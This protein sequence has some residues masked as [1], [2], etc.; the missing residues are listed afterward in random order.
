MMFRL[1]N[2]AR[3]AELCRECGVPVPEEDGIVSSRAELDG[4]S[5]PFGEMDIILKRLES[6]IN[7][8]EEIK[9]VPRGG[10]APASV[11]PSPEDPWQWQ[12]FI[13][14]SSSLRIFLALR[15]LL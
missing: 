15:R 12:R 5:V 6:T 13:K 8:E 4:D 14:A 11:K 10:K 7:R 3:F 9:I 1:D 2:K